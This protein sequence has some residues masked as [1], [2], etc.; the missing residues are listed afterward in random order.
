MASQKAFR[1]HRM[2]DP[3]ESAH[4]GR[5]SGCANELLKQRALGQAPKHDL[6]EEQEEIQP[7]EQIAQPL[8]AVAAGA[9]S[10]YDMDANS[11]RAGTLVEQAR[12]LEPDSSP[13]NFR[14]QRAD[15]LKNLEFIGSGQYPVRIATAPSAAPASLYHPHTVDTASAAHR[16]RPAKTLA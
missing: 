13:A 5:W 9:S 7:L 14:E 15:S 11:A 1:K 10:Q 2:P 12:M 8:S 4:F 3:L 6:E 16:H